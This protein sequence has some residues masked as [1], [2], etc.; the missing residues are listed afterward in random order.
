[1]DM[2]SF[3][4][5]R[6]AVQENAHRADPQH[7]AALQGA[8]ER[9]LR[10]SR[11]FAEVELGRTDDPDQMVIGVCRCAD[12]VAP[13]EAGVGVERLWGVLALESK[14]EAH[15]VGCTESLME[16]EGAVTVDDAGHYIT[17]HLVAEPAPVAEPVP[18]EEPVPAATA[19]RDETATAGSPTV[20]ATI[21][22]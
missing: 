8:L 5:L 2:T 18:A 19:Q 13:W 17:V 21:D 7:A 14:W 11:L 4:K 22:A 3:H 10:A 12:E 1:M 6:L 16:F 15:S 20:S 9:S